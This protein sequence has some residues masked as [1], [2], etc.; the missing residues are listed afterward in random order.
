MLCPCPAHETVHS[1]MAQSGLGHTL[2][3][4]QRQNAGLLSPDVIHT[5]AMI[6]ESGELRPN[7]D[8]QQ[9]PPA[10]DWATLG[11]SEFDL[12]GTP[13]TAVQD[14]GL[15]PTLMHQHRVGAVAGH[16]STGGCVIANV[17]QGSDRGGSGWVCH[18][19]AGA[20]SFRGAGG[21][22]SVV[23]PSVTALTTQGGHEWQRWPRR[24]QHTRESDNVAAVS[25]MTS[26]SQG[27]GG[28]G[29]GRAGGVDM[30]APAVASADE[31]MQD[32]TVPPGTYATP[33]LGGIARQTLVVAMS[34]CQPQLQHTRAEVVVHG[35]A[36]MVRM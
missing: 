14:T 6:M 30:E 11:Q 34:R 33:S 25:D 5:S 16:A 27:R 20:G 31:P 28:G 23:V 8:V 9:P 10:I 21:D 1:E 2:P 12:A 29:W 22:Q 15:R 7:V 36:M 17:G 19:P 18:H 26:P 3:Q 24:E 35:A 32:G 13:A 4:T